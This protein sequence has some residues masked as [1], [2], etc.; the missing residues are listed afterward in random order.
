MRFDHHCVISREVEGEPE[1]DDFGN[2]VAAVDL[3][4]IY[5]GECQVFPDEVAM[6]RIS[7]GDASL[8]GRSPVRLARRP[9]VAPKQGDWLAATFNG[10]M[11]SGEIEAVA[12][13]SA[14]P[15]LQVRWLSE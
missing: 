6:K 3:M 11:R 2:P 12:D 4:T 14:Y 10:V 7:T 8:I 13:L 5:D 1:F 15:R 9:Q